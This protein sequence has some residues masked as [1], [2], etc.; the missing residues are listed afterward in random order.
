[1]PG[2]PRNDNTKPGQ[3]TIETAKRTL[4]PFPADHI[5]CRRFLQQWHLG[6]NSTII[7]LHTGGQERNYRCGGVIAVNWKPD[8]P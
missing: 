1:M 4:G 2:K 6:Y 8:E 3:V 5:V 7:T